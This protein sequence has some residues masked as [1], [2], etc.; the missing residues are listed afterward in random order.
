M[1]GVLAN[2]ATVIVGSILG[3]IFNKSIPNN[4][5]A[6]LMKCLG[7][8]SVFMG[9]SGMYQNN[10]HTLV[11]IL[12]IV[13]GTLIGIL[14]NIDKWLNIGAEFVGSKFKSKGSNGHS[15]AE[16]FVSASLLFCVGAMTVVG[17]LQAGLKGDNG[18]LFTK[19]VLDFVSSM[20][21]ASTLGFGVILSVFTVIII[22][23]GIVLL[24]QVIAPVLSDLV[25]DNMVVC[26]SIM[27]FALG[28]NLIGL[29]KTKIA[30]MLPAIFMPIAICPL[31]SFIA[32]LLNF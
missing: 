6:A 5:A 12:S 30:N 14:I 22:Q 13:S 26:G 28:L 9:I 23:G 21:F 31:V 32:G 16:G 18:T 2:A 7:F 1:L 8:C 17:S 20:I 3:L 15:I 11:I 19:A 27:I 29:T 10:T 24:A 25:I 4:V